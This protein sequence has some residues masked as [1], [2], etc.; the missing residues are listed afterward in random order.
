LCGCF[1][2]GDPTRPV[3][4]GEIQGPALGM[5]VDVFDDDGRPLPSGTGEL[6]CT[7]PFPSQPLGFWGD[8]DG[9]R[10]HAAYYDRFPG[11][12]AHGDFAAWT[13]HGGM[14]IYGRSDATLN[15][16]GVRIGTAEIY[17]QV[18]QLDEIAEAIAVGQQWDGDT[19]IVLF[20]RMAPGAVLTD[21][22]QAEIRRRLRTNCSPRHVPA[23][24]VEVGDIPRTRSGKITEL[25]VADVVNGRTVRN[26]EALANPEALDLFKGRPELAV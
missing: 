9:S 10:Y 14:V 18:E 7:K 13:A 8:S 1:V 21:E 24:I 20:V 6:V 22:L 12:W 17:R 26:V 2:G 15:A 25:A 19:R 23:R 4:A 5:A 3:W 11:V 16:A